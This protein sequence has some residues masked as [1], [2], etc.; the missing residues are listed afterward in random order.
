ML[1]PIHVST[2]NQYATLSSLRSAETDQNWFYGLSEAERKDGLH[3][4]EVGNV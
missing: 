2:L 3:F 1:D 4:L